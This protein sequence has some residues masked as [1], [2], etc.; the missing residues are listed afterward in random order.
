MLDPLDILTNMDAVRPHYQPIFSADEQKIIGYEIFG[1]IV[2]D[3]E[4]KSLGPFFLDPTIPEEYKMEVDEKIL[5]N[6]LENFLTADPDLLVFINQDANILMLDHGE[7]FLAILKE[8]E[9][10][11]LSLERIVIE[12]TEH[13]FTGDIEQLY[14]MLMYYKT[15]GI[16]IA[17]DNIGKENSNLDRIALLSPDLLKIDLQALKLS[18]PS[19]TYEYVLYT[20]ALLARK[21]GATLLFED[22]EANFQLQYAWRNG[23]RYFQ[24]YYLQRPGEEFIDR[25]MLKERLQNEFNQFI[26]HEKRKLE[27]VH[28]YSEQFY[29]RVHQ[30]V[31]AFKKTSQ[32]NDDLIV[33]LAESLTDCTFR[34]Y[35]CNENG[36]Q[37]T[38]NVLKKGEEWILQSEYKMKNW[39]WRPYFLENILKMNHLKKGV[40]SDLYSDIET[41]EMI[42]TYSYPVDENVYL[43]IDLPYSHLYEQEGLI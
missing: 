42:R 23:G 29:K 4:I 22:I 27:T 36:F 39:S 28:D 24:G 16:K 7:A 37:L 11:G 40:L 13:N 32:S 2:I 21:I 14:H 12:I 20:I 35:M 31:T 33:K 34:I 41:G 6:A 9:E 25:S 5:K 43:F 18:S 8:F 19:P 1:R 38:A 10:R 3:S 30:N 15:C 26:T 17:V